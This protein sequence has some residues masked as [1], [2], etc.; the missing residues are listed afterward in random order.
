[1]GLKLSDGMN[2]CFEVVVFSG[3]KILELILEVME[4][5]VDFNELFLVVL[6]EL[7][8]VLIEGIGFGLIEHEGLNDGSEIS[9]KLVFDKGEGEKVGEFDVGD[10]FLFLELVFHF[11]K[12]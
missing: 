3:L 6:L 10:D 1:L 11:D 8:M 5:I 12:L 2:G 4:K 7:T 9:L